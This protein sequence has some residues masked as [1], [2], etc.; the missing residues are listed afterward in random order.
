[1]VQYTKILLT[2]LFTCLTAG[3]FAATSQLHKTLGGENLNTI[4]NAKFVTILPLNR[5]NSVMDYC[6]EPEIHLSNAEINRLKRQLLDDHNYVFDKVKSCQ[7][8]PEI[9]LKFKGDQDEE[10]Y[11]FISPICNQILFSMG[12]SSALLNYDPAHERLE[13][14]FQQLI[15]ESRIK[16]H[17]HRRAYSKRGF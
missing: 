3:S 11:V 6:H 10:I 5:G 9:S 2:L 12:G 7:F 14:Y 4:K 15:T 16:N 1:M 13:P 8:I 17:A